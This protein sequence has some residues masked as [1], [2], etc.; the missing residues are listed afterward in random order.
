MLP[1]CGERH[2]SGAGGEVEE[3]LAGQPV[4]QRSQQ[5][6]GDGFETAGD[7]RVV[8]ATSQG[9]LADIIDRKTGAVQPA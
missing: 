5:V 2:I 3:T 8:S 9:G 4:D 6:V 7:L 1:G